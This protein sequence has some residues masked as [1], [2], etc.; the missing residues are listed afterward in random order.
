MTESNGLRAVVVLTAFLAVA[1]AATSLPP[2]G[3]E[4]SPA[5][6]AQG[7][8]A[9]VTAPV[10]VVVLDREGR[11]VTDLGPSDFTVTID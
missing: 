6:R 9:A 5:S 1:A 8:Q 10:E 11:A 3:V 2:D 7:S 4:A